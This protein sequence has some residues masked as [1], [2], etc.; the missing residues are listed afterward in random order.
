M[1][2]WREKTERET[3]RVSGSITGPWSCSTCSSTRG[4]M[5]LCLSTGMCVTL[6]FPFWLFFF[7][8]FLV[9]SF[10]FE[11]Q[12][13]KVSKNISPRAPWENCLLPPVPKLLAVTNTYLWGW[14]TPWAMKDE[15]SKQLHFFFCLIIT[16]G[17]MYFSPLKYYS[18]SISPFFEYTKS[19]KQFFFTLMSPVICKFLHP[20]HTES[21]DWVIFGLPAAQ[22]MHEFCFVR[23]YV[24]LLEGSLDCRSW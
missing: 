13:H 1:W 22:G 11:W 8:S 21:Q 17:K 9:K 6:E 18:Q 16:V 3:E 23:L 2:C 10:L 15:E 12:S 4:C 20:Q 5:T 24:M 19:R 14:A 7:L